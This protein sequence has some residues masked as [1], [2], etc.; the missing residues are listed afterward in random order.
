MIL[1]QPTSPNDNAR[2]TPTKIVEAVRELFGGVIS[3]DPCSDEQAQHSVRAEHYICPPN[4]GLTAPWQGSVFCNP[5]GGLLKLPECTPCKGTRTPGAT[6][7]VAVWWAKLLHEYEQGKVTQAVYVCFNLEA[8]RN[9]QKFAAK[10]CQAFPH[11]VPRER[12]E[13]PSS[14]EGRSNAPGGAS[15]IVYLGQNNER[16]VEIFSR[17]GYVRV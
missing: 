13:Y 17:F 6:S 15:A 3:L 4:N 9:T 1:D 2:R 16:F 5:P 12:L 10:P 11:C 14:G 8:F 7:S